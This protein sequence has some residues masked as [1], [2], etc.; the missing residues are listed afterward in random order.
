VGGDAVTTFADADETQ[1][2]KI[3]TCPVC[4]CGLELENCWNGCDEGYFDGY[5]DDP[6]WYDP[7]DLILCSA[8]GGRGGYLVCPNA[9]HHDK[10]KAGDQ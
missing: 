3:Q 8:C 6:L 9:E 2:D 5:D 1:H 10:I 4:G 7:G